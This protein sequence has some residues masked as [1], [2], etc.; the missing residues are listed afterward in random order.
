MQ[1]DT[2]L[3]DLRK[4]FKQMTEGTKGYPSENKGIK[5]I[6][7]YGDKKPTEVDRPV[8]SKG[9]SEAA[10]TSGVKGKDGET[11]DIGPG[12]KKAAG[13]GTKPVARDEGAV[14]GKKE[15]GDEHGSKKSAGEDGGVKRGEGVSEASKGGAAEGTKVATGETKEGGEPYADFRKKI[16][17]TL[18]L[19]GNDKIVNGPLNK[20]NQGLGKSK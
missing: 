18:G 17:S 4:S 16:R 19:S 5:P 6:S 11:K 15:V 2:T 3:N 12:T 1:E 9:G 13:D 8:G 7:G 14:A 20:P 10:G